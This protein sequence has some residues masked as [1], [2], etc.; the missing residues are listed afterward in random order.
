MPYLT[1]ETT[2]DQYGVIHAKGKRERI[3]LVTNPLAIINRTIPEVMVEGSITFIIDKARKYAATLETLEEQK[4]FIFDIISI[5]NPIEGQEINDLWITLSDREKKEFIKDAISLNPDGTLRTDNGFYV[6][7]E[8]FEDNHKI[9]DAIIQ[10]Y[11]KY[12]NVFNPYHI[13]VPKP[14][15]GRDIYVGDDYVGYQYIMMLKQSGKKQFSVRSAGS[16]SD[17]SLPEKSNDNKLSKSEHSTKPI[18]FGE[19]ELPHFEVM[20]APEDFALITALY[21]SSVDGRKYMYEAVISDDSEYN[22]PDTFTSRTSQILQTYFKSLGVKMETIY[23]DDEYIE[24]PEHKDEIVAYKVANDIIFCSVADMYYLK[25]LHKLY[26][27]FMKKHPN[28]IDDTDE[29]WDYIYENLPFKKKELT[30]NI[31]DLFNNHLEAFSQM[32]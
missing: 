3:E 16:I 9:R 1:E 29:I 28:E 19:Y 25:K 10:I 7:W 23:D 26:K 12:P 8:A 13:F 21:R 24:E 18:R 5:L 14:K 31:I 6:R 30:D 15:W 2:K 17:E 22:I 27:Q 4:D 32:Q 20:T 11:D